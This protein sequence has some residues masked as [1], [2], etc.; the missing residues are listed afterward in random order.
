[1]HQHAE[2]HTH[3]DRQTHTPCEMQIQEETEHVFSVADRKRHEKG[4]GGGR[5]S[6]RTESPLSVPSTGLRS[7]LRD[8]VMNPRVPAETHHNK[9]LNLFQHKPAHTLV[10]FDLA[11]GLGRGGLGGRSQA[12]G[13]V[14]IDV[15][16]LR[17]VAL[18]EKKK[19]RKRFRGRFP[20]T[21]RVRECATSVS[22][23]DGN[24]Y[25]LV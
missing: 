19:G 11:G 25:R 8:T 5:C 4:G 9:T 7:V 23:P 17:G 16:M 21:A 3:T 12:R 18:S 1:M 24:G 14:V 6:D 13:A 2:T 20:R 22:E 10:C 15:E